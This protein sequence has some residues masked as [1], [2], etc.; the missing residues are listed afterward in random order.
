MTENRH[1]RGRVLDGVLLVLGIAAFLAAAWFL[2][3]QRW[4]GQFSQVVVSGHSMEPTY[5]SG[6][7]VITRTA[8]RY[9]VGDSLVYRVPKDQPGEG[10]LVVHR[11]IGHDG[12]GYLLQG[13]NRTT[14]DQWRPRD[15]DVVGRVIAVV[16]V[17][18]KIIIGLSNPWIL[19]LLFGLIITLW[20]WPDRDPV[21]SRDHENDAA[22]DD[23]TDPRSP[24]VRIQRVALLGPPRDEPWWADE[25]PATAS[26][27][28]DWWSDGS[29]PDADRSDHVMPSAT[30]SSEWDEITASA[31][32]NSESSS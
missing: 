23:A 21:M 3:P 9:R 14:P 1:I 28:G 27:G 12:G 10:L 29:S 22:T 13:D 32:A 25:S 20:C 26:G 16:P 5:H 7:L 15:R 2:F 24:T 19:A 8:D 31:S 30:T 11:V 18:G 6:D 4:G 17:A